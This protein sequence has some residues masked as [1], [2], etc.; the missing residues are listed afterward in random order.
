[1]KK[2]LFAIALAVAM[3]L[4]A[5]PMP[6]RAAF[7]E[8]TS[9]PAKD[10]KYYY[11]TSYNPFTVGECTWYAWGR[12][13]EITG[14]RPTWST[15]GNADV[16]HTNAK[17]AGYTVGSTPKV[18]SIACWGS[19]W[20]HV[21]VVERID[22]NGNPVCSE[23]N[24]NSSK[25]FKT[26]TM[27]TKT[28]SNWAGNNYK[29]YGLPKYYIYLLNDAGG[30]STTP[31]GPSFSFNASLIY[32]I[33]PQCAPDRCL[34]IAGGSTENRAN[35][36]ISQKTG[37]KNQQFQFVSVGDGY[38]KIVPQNSQK[39]LDCASQG[40]TPGTNVQQYDFS[41]NH[42]SQRWWVEDAGNGYCYIVPKGNTGLCLDVVD[43]RDADGTN[44]QL[45]TRNSGAPQKWK[46]IPACNGN[47]TWGNW[48]TTKNA[49]CGVAGQKQRTCSSCGTKETQTIA[50]LSH[51]WGSWTTTKSAS[52]GVTGQRQRVCSRCGQRESETIAALSH[53]YQKTASM[54][55][56]DVFT[57]THCGDSYRV[58]TVTW[59]DIPVGEQD[60]QSVGVRNFS[61]H[62]LSC[63]LMIA[64]YEDGRL[65]SL[66]Q[67][68]L[69]LSSL[70][71][72]YTPTPIPRE[73]GNTTW[74]VFLLDP[75]TLT[76]ILPNLEY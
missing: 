60:F 16:W 50:A 31:T 24:R 2:R 63:N 25:A 48:T 14:T 67:K 74:K 39:S 4:A 13:Y 35:V 40:T 7:T 69:D 33:S 10:N 41:N 21:A 45:Y 61:D 27:T 55:A 23:F 32:V 43:G 15:L 19:T 34:D 71:S 76:P 64:S 54:P 62:Q 28:N 56:Y 11:D 36:Q 58:D 1:M 12:A 20:N 70:T 3:V 5:A 44:V 26:E 66:F 42:D 59:V 53:D 75:E 22:A 49:S 65:T 51:S 17:N 29:V 46:L 72:E 57:C 37:G 8:R 9:A 30:E 6:A 52:C 47:H 38:Y 68:P 73:T 18:G